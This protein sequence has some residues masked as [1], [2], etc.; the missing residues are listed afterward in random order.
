MVGQKV[1]ELVNENKSA[2]DYKITWNASNQPSGLY[3]VM[4]STGNQTV[5]QKITLIK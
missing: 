1:A 3:F 5:S 4:L 2:G